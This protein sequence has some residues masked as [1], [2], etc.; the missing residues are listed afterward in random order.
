M[1]QFNVSCVL[2]VSRYDPRR[3]DKS[4]NPFQLDSKKIKTELASY[5]DGQNRF[6]QLKRASVTTA[7]ELHG[8][9]GQGIKERHKKYQKM[10]MDDY[11]MLEYLKTQLGETVD[12]E[13]GS[14]APASKIVSH[15]SFSSVV[16]TAGH[17]CTRRWC[18]SRVCFIIADHRTVRIR[19]RK[20]R[21]IGRRFQHR[22]QAP[23][24]PS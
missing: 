4:L 10:A 19:D 9:L 13:K 24:N 7:G 11:E 22:I 2:F 3:K 18:S 21:C 14:G 23:W 5:L 8:D 1:P 12:T 20:C 17:K 6:E 16:C 15:L